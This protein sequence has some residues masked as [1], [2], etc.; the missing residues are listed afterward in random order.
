MH[1]LVS[2]AKNV[3][4]DVYEIANSRSEYY[5]LIS[6]E[7]YK[8]QKELEKKREQR[9]KRNQDGSGQTPMDQTN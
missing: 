1:N 2:Y 9:C 6:G 7:I 8:I 5:H 3:E 4:K